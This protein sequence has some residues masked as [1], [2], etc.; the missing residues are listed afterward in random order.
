MCVCV[1][2]WYL[3]FFFS[4]WLNSLCITGSRFIR[5]EI[6][7]ERKAQEGGNPSI[8]MCVYMYIYPSLKEGL[9][10][11]S[12]VL[13]WRIPQTEEPGGLLSLGLHRVGHNWSDLAAAAAGQRWIFPQ[14]PRET[15]IK[16]SS[17]NSIQSS[18]SVVFD[19][20]WPQGLQHTRLPCPSLTLGACSNS[21]PSSQWC[22]PTIILCHPL[23]LPY[24][25]PKKNFLLHP[26]EAK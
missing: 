2:V 17:I 26:K 7:K 16:T 25:I 10:T 21:C 6:G 4:F 9:A 14:V 22:H 5:G 19:S 24:C 18:H 8:Y 1:N 12:S 3:F 15:P 20:L 23:L 11:H 13:A